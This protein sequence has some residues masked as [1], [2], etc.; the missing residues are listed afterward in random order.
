M[1][2]SNSSSDD[3]QPR[4]PRKRKRSSSERGLASDHDLANLARTYLEVQHRLW[5]ALVTQGVLSAMTDDVIQ[6]MVVHYK[7]C[8]QSQRLDVTTAMDRSHGFQLKLAAAYA[9]YSCDN[10]SPTSIVDQMVNCLHKAHAEGRFIPWEFIFTDYSVSGLD[11]GRR[12]YLNCKELI[13]APEKPIDTVYIDDFTRASRDSLEWWKLG[14]FCKRRSLRM[15]GATDG[16]DL[17]SPNWDIWITIYGLLCRLFIRSLQEKVGRGMKGAARRRTCLGKPPMGFTRKLMRDVDG[18]PIVSPSGGPKFTWS[19]DPVSRQFVELLFELF[20]DRRM[21]AYAIAKLF[22]Q[23][24][25]DGTD[26]WSESTI[27]NMLWNP[28]YIGVFIW[29]RTRRE[30]DFDKEKYVTVQNPRSE[31]IVTFDPSQAIIAGADEFAAG[32]WQVKNLKTGEQARLAE[33]DIAGFVGMTT[34]QE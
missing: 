30:F 13:N 8:H 14:W 20:V 21:S 2:F 4:A 24:K 6:Q 15:I 23:Q 19:I 16:F 11:S 17:S 34:N 27:K 28:A 18:N 3:L 32:V 12:G 7:E 29:N 22:N 9:R 10:S 31:W 26:T 1:S 25:I 5:P 33:A